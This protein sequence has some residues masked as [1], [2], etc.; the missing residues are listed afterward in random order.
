MYAIWHLKLSVAHDGMPLSM[1]VLT[2][3]MQ[4]DVPLSVAEETLIVALVVAVLVVEFDVEVEVPEL[5]VLLVLEESE[6]CV[7]QPIKNKVLRKSRDFV[8]MGSPFVSRA[9]NT[10]NRTFSGV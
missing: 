7:A 1:L 3:V 6:P 9:K 10:E 4:P 8:F 2:F 5:D